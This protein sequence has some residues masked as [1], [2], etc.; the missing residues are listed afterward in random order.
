MRYEKELE[1]L[2]FSSLIV[3]AVLLVFGSL[4]VALYNFTCLNME[5]TDFLDSVTWWQVN[6]L[7]AS[8]IVV[9]LVSWVVYYL[10]FGGG[11][12]C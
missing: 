9:F 11:Y 10:N 5:Y 3:I 1:A 12:E 2:V 4:T 8:M 6:Q 7:R